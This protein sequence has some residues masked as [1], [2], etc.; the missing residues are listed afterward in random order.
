MEVVLKL[1]DDGD[2]T[3]VDRAR[4]RLCQKT[5]LFGGLIPVLNSRAVKAAHPQ[6]GDH[7]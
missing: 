5:P 4:S 6:G 2:A 7:G 3:L 1:K